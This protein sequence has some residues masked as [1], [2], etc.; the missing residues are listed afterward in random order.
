MPI[1]TVIFQV[2][3]SSKSLFAMRP[4]YK[5][6][7]DYPRRL[8]IHWIYIKI[9]PKK[10]TLTLMLNPNLTNPNRPTKKT[11]IKLQVKYNWRKMSHVEHKPRPF[12]L[13]ESTLTREL[14]G[15][16]INRVQSA[17]INHIH[18]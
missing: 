11:I 18:L 17:L 5:H 4:I 8:A 13:Q 16:L 9:D 6:I 1:L 2:N 15:Q 14:A 3:L 10:L 12:S 7:S